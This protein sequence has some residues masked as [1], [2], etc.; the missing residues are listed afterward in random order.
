MFE[1]KEPVIDVLSFL[2]QTVDAA[3]NASVREELE[4]KGD[5]HSIALIDLLAEYGISGRRAIEFA[6]KLSNLEKLY[7]TNKDEGVSED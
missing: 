1:N 5:E 3:I 4:K 2:E 6:Y 7:G